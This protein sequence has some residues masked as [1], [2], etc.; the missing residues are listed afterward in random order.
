M[1]SAISQIRAGDVVYCAREAMIVIER[2]ETHIL[3]CPLV[4][5]DEPRHR[6]DQV[7]EWTDLCCAGLTTT[8]IRARAVPCFR[9]IKAI[10]SV[11]QV[12]RTVWQRIR[13][14]AWREQ[15]LRTAERVPRRIR[16]EETHTT[17]HRRAPMA[18]HRRPSLSK[19]AVVSQ[20]D[21]AVPCGGS[22]RQ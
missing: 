7:L 5:D 12:P 14:A 13:A 6:A 21:C 2:N 3:A 4:S 15:A 9:S 10:Q 22:P 18:S 17:V 20:M 1:M 16:G 8:H 11:G 19:V